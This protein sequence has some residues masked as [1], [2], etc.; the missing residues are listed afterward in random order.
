[1]TDTPTKYIHPLQELRAR[2][3]AAAGAVRGAHGELPVPP[4]I[5][6]PKREGQGDYSTNA[7]MLLA[8]VLGAAPRV[9]AERLAEELSGRLG[10]DLDTAEVAGPGFLNLTLS[11]GWHQKALDSVLAAGAAYGAGGAQPSERILIEFV[12]ANPTGPLVAASGRHAAYGDALARILAHHGHDV[13]REYYFNDAGNQ[14]RLLGE[15]VRARARGEAVP[16][17][18]YQGDYVLELAEQIPGAAERDPEELAA[19]AVEIQLA[20]IKATL[21]RY[22]V[23]Y[24]DFFSERALHEGSPSGVDRA[25]ELLEQAGHTYRSDGAVWLRTTAFGDNKDRVVVRSNGEPTYLAAD[26]AYLQNKRERGFERQLLPVGA[27]HHAYAGELKAAM[28]ALGGDPETVEVPILQFVHLVEGS[29]RAAFSKRKGSF[30]T[31]DDLLDEIGV[32]ATRF[33][34]L[35]RSHDR[36]VDL[37]LDLARSQSAENPV[38]YVQYA[39]ARIAS[40]LARLPAGR[41]EAAAADRGGWEAEQLHPSERKLINKLAALPDEITEAVERRAPHRI[42]VYALELA[43]E[44]TAFYRDCRVLGVTPEPLESFRIALSVAAQRTIALS[45]ALLGVSA[46]DSM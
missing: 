21:E 25:L 29:E 19:E 8:P 18:G 12:S 17:G 2:V 35:Q 22:G 28:A 38:Y 23:R 42:T 34:M 36:T 27:D 31:L 16:E 39:H 13:S 45:L 40:M 6:R 3:S 43:Q 11:S 46:P 10:E 24:D 33:F 32:D 26:I 7:A 5:E 4:R 20:K 14:I 30:V 9:I 1:M 44:F 37:D 15:S 41:V